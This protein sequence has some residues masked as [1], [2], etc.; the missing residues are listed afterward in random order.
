MTNTQNL[1]IDNQQQNRGSSHHNTFL[2]YV[3][4]GNSENRRFEC[5]TIVGAA[6]VS[7]RLPFAQSTNFIK[8]DAFYVCVQTLLGHT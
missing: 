3:N 6:S 2:M 1:K 8:R 7:R 4:R 5:L